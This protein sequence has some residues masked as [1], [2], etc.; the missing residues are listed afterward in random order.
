MGLT[1]WMSKPASIACWRSSRWPY[2]VSAIR[3][4]PERASSRMRRAISKPSIAGRPTSTMARSGSIEWM[5]AS[6]ARPLSADSHSKPASVERLAQHLPA[7]GVVLDD[8]RRRAPRRRCS[9]SLRAGLPTAAT[10]ARASGRRTVNSAPRPRRRS[11]AIDGAAMHGHERADKREPDP[12]ARPARDR[13]SAPPARRG[14]RP[15]RACSSAMPAPSSLTRMIACALLAAERE[16][17]RGRR[18]ACT[19]PRC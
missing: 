19:S 16:R 15:S 1:T 3:R 11:R 14:R 7:V 9:A 2:P 12:D 18:A 5:S 17:G 10:G 8:R 6:P 13:A 4:T